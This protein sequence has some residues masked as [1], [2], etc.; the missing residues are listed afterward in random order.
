MN[1]IKFLIILFLFAFINII[2]SDICEA[3]N[4]ALMVG[5]N[6]YDNFNSTNG[7][8]Q[9]CVNDILH[10]KQILVN[11]YGFNEG[12]IKTLLDG[13][14]KRENIISAFEEHIINQ[15]EEGD[16]VLFHFSGHGTYLE[17]DNGDEGDGLDEAL[18]TAECSVYEETGYIRDDILGSLIDRVKTDNVTIILDCCHSGTATRLV[19]ANPPKSRNIQ[20]F[21]KNV[22]Q[23]NVNTGETGDEGKDMINDTVKAKGVVI[24]GCSA[25]QTSADAFWPLNSGATEGIWMGALS[26][27]LYEALLFAPPDSTYDDIMKN[28]KYKI[29]SDGYE[30]TPQLEGL[31]K[32]KSLFKISSENVNNDIPVSAV[33]G[34]LVEL[35]LGCLAGGVTVGSVYEIYPPGEKKSY[36]GKIEIVETGPLKS[37]G[38]II[39]GTVQENSRAVQVT[40]TYTDVVLNLAIPSQYQSNSLTAELNKLGYVKIVNDFPCD[41]VLQGDR[42]GNYDYIL[43]YPDGKGVAGFN[44]QNTEDLVNQLKPWLENAYSIK[45]LASLDSP[46]P[47]FKL[48]LWTDKSEP[49]YYI[50]KDY[51]TF[52]FKSEKDCYLTLI[53]VGTDGTITILFP[54]R[55]CQDNKITAGKV[56]KIPS[57]DM[58]FKI[59]VAGPA[60]QELVK[61]IATENPLDLS[62]MVANT[63]AAFKSVEN[64]VSYVG[65]LPG[66]LLKGL[67]VESNSGNSE[68]TLELSGWVTSSVL[69][70]IKENN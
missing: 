43:Y 19:T 64:P 30:Q 27:N 69:L 17:D 3:K 45:K 35:N 32:S 13:E 57:E 61:A 6:N 22:Q 26:K 42:E 67:S 68:N 63:G 4:I 7:D 1:K 24:T 31:N 38:K 51:V 48:D 54:N 56:Y 33:K 14:A 50:G 39:D 34:N 28:V 59:K 37:S 23:S 15:A 44:I 70:T 41:R 40:K 66:A 10:I 12:D 11:K 20:N 2:S 5:I 52:N 9:G 62:A 8:L 16:V 58:G 18:C 36:T 47:D 46:Y 55:T 25:E 53:D 49:L 21:I 65:E 60:G 29:N